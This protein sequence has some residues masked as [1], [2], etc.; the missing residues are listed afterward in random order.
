MLVQPPIE[1]RII[2]LLIYIGL[3]AVKT[4]CSPMK[5]ISNNRA[6]GLALKYCSLS[7]GHRHRHRHH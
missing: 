4:L 7:S 3:N 1:P 2:N 6:R 5:K